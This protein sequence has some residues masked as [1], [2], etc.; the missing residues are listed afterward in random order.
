M[1]SLPAGAGSS[2]GGLEMRG[3]TWLRARRRG[4]RV[5]CVRQM[6]GKQLLAKN[7]NASVSHLS[8]RLWM[9]GLWPTLFCLVLETEEG[10]GR[11]RSASAARLVSKAAHEKKKRENSTTRST[12]AGRESRCRGKHKGR[13]IS[14]WPPATGAGRRSDEGATSSWIEGMASMKGEGAD[15]PWCMASLPGPTA[16]PGATC[17][18]PGRGPDGAR[19]AAGPAG[20][21]AGAAAAAAASSTSR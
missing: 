16:A 6:G 13:R 14:Q 15:V 9:V 19:A 20:P 1:V 12:Q 21:A 10:N 2:S 11:P 4:S 7:Y 17:W 8:L 3:D 5:R 18:G